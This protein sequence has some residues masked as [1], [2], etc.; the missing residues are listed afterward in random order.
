MSTPALL[1]QSRRA[2]LI[3]RF[4]GYGAFPVHLL[5]AVPRTHHEPLLAVIQA[6]RLQACGDVHQQ[7]GPSEAGAAKWR[8]LPERATDDQLN[9]LWGL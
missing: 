6:V 7:G 3:Q 2:R 4:S 5:A 9:F 1:R 8:G